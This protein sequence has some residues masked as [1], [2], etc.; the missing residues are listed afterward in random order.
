MHPGISQLCSLCCCNPLGS[1]RE[2]LENGC[3]QFFHPVSSLWGLYAPQITVYPKGWHL[4]VPTDTTDKGGVGEAVRNPHPMA[5]AGRN[6][7]GFEGSRVSLALFQAALCHRSAWELSQ[8]NIQ[9]SCHD[10]GDWN[11]SLGKPPWHCQAQST[12]RPSLLRDEPAT[13]SC[14]WRNV[15][16]VPT[17][18]VHNNCS[19]ARRVCSP[20]LPSASR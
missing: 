4:S 10:P 13:V 6:P 12:A 17:R 1:R 5:P 7:T 3:L 9:G 2:H 18:A 14:P 8:N 11:V 15:T 20:A 16:A 19:H